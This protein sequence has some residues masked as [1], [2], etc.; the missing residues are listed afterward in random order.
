MEQ[1][2]RSPIGTGRIF[3]VSDCLHGNSESGIQQVISVPSTAQGL[4]GACKQKE[5]FRFW[6][7]RKLKR[8][9]ISSFR[10]LCYNLKTESRYAGEDR[11]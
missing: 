4:G 6:R 1:F 10:S 2:S 5:A 7:L 3:H 8:I 11:A 9:F